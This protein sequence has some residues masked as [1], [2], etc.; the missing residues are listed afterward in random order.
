M[1]VAVA[2][3]Q[4][5]RISRFSHEEA[6]EGGVSEGARQTKAKPSPRVKMRSF[7]IGGW[8]AYAC[9]T[10]RKCSLAWASGADCA[11]FRAAPAPAPARSD[12]AVLF[13]NFVCAFAL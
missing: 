8:G 9:C 3:S 12:F 7:G 2:N 10:N 4:A 1:A 11:W 13:L 5:P 6:E